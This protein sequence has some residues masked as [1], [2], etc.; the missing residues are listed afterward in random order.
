MS[1]LDKFDHI[2]YR[3]KKPQILAH[4]LRASL[5]DADIQAF[6][7]K[8]DDAFRAGKAYE[9][10]ASFHRLMPFTEPKQTPAIKIT[11]LGFDQ[12]K[13]IAE[14]DE[15]GY[16]PPQYELTEDQ[17][18]M[19]EDAIE[20]GL[21]EEYPEPEQ[22]ELP[23]PLPPGQ[24]ARENSILQGATTALMHICT[25]L[26]KEDQRKLP[27]GSVIEIDFHGETLT[28]KISTEPTVMIERIN[29]LKSR[30]IAARSSVQPSA[31]AAPDAE[32]APTRIRSPHHRGGNGSSNGSN[33]SNGSDPQPS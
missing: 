6:D 14:F 15:S 10:G 29:D 17:R 19:I 23:R 12:L 16:T 31:I 9:R 18:A 21:I 32:P 20:S 28:M 33:G 26:Y 11:V 27:R 5:L 4:Y 8:Q 1:N 30:V 25:E 13:Q 24:A 22:P 7:L 2:E 3:A